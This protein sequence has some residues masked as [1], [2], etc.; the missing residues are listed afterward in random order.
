MSPPA[1]RDRRGHRSGAVAGSP[2]SGGQP[3]ALLVDPVGPQPHNERELCT[4][5]CALLAQGSNLSAAD[6][7]RMVEGPSADSIGWFMRTLE[8]EGRLRQASDAVVNYLRSHKIASHPDLN[9]HDRLVD[10]VEATMNCVTS[11]VP[12]PGHHQPVSADH[13]RLHF[14]CRTATVMAILE[15]A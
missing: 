7:A 15:A 12:A 8:E 3:S 9:A 11:S 1:Q 4:L 13:R 6:L 10:S 2:D 14:L 5:Y